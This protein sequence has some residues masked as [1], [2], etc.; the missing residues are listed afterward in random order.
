MKVVTSFPKEKERIIKSIVNLLKNN[1]LLTLATTNKNQSFCNTAYYVFDKKFNVYIWTGIHTKH[2]KNIKENN[3]VAINIFNSTQKWGSLLQGIQ[4]V[5]HA[6]IAND[7]ELLK[8][9]LLYMKRYPKCVSLIKSPKELHSK[10]YE[11]KIYKIEIDK[12]KVFDEKSFGKEEFR[13]V[14]IKR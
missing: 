3:R 13:E 9:G 8:A 10:I 5:G 14:V 2:S 11:S 4:A 1:K 6:S 12:I 7:Q